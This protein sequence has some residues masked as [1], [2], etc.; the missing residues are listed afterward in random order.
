MCSKMITLCVKQRIILSHNSC[1]V[2]WMAECSVTRRKPLEAKRSAEW[3][4]DAMC[5]WS[6]CPVWLPIFRWVGT[7]GMGD[8]VKNLRVCHKN[9]QRRRTGC[10]C[11]FCLFEYFLVAFVV[12]SVFLFRTLRLVTFAHSIRLFTFFFLATGQTSLLD[13][14][15]P[16]QM[17]ST[18]SLKA[19]SLSRVCRLFFLRLLFVFR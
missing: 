10:F 11:G 3:E 6:R 2:A 19:E 4:F 17:C 15:Q 9:D 7:R 13:D 18:L 5:V 16:T 8:K 14:S 1:Y 12:L